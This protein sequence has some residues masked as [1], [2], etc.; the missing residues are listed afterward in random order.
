MKTII[1]NLKGLDIECN[2]CGKLIG[3]NNYKKHY[4]SCGKSNK[5]TNYIGKNWNKNKNYVEIFGEEKA[6]EIKQKLSNSHKNRVYCKHSIETKNKIST[7]MLNNKNW[8]FSG[9][10]KKG[11]FEGDYFGSSWELAY[12]VYC[13]ENSI[14]IERNWNS[15]KYLNSKGEEKNY[16]PDFYLL[17]EKKFIEIKGYVTEDSLL[18]EKYFKYN[19]ETIDENKIKPILKFVIEKY[20]KDFYNILKEDNINFIEKNKNYCECGKKILKKSIKCHSCKMK[21]KRKLRPDYNTLLSEVE[22]LGY[23]GTG[24]K[25]GVS[26][27]AIRKWIKN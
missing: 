11:Y 19:I 12:M 24:R 27:N 18:K 21:E 17:E 9:L 8:L 25:Y 3:K 26:D 5:K 6:S 20:G 2:K 14:K 23:S 22:I 15:F 7:K 1:E 4:N 13:K 10:G 16:I